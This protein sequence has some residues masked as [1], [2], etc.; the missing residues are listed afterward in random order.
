MEQEELKAGWRVYLIDG[1]A[2]EMYPD[3]PYEESDEGGGEHL[4]GPFT[5]CPVT[6]QKVVGR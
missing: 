5:F 3:G 6:V 1:D 4:D 2:E